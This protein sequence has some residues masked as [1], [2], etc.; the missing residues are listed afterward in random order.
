[1]SRLSSHFI[2][3][4]NTTNTDINSI[5]RL[6]DSNQRVNSYLPY[7]HHDRVPTQTITPI[8][9]EE[10]QHTLQGLGSMLQDNFTMD[11]DNERRNNKLGEKSTMAG[12]DDDFL[13][14]QQLHGQHKSRHHSTSQWLRQRW[15]RLPRWIWLVLILLF[16]M[17][18]VLLM[19]FLIPRMPTVKLTDTETNQ[20]PMWSNDRSS[21]SAEWNVSITLDNSMNWIPTFLQKLNVVVE[22]YDTKAQVGYGLYDDSQWLAPHDYVITM[23]V[24]IAYSGTNAS[25]DTL[26][27]LSTICGLE[28][29]SVGPTSLL[30][31]ELFNITFQIDLS[32][33]GVPWFG[34][35]T[36][37]P[38]HGIQCP[39]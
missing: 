23:P 27:D 35:T 34:H 37:I 29:Q 1:M 2:T 13:Q 5:P 10:E 36:I 15:Y 33:R 7:S 14:Q 12:G 18:F 4:H 19:Y 32:V 3:D 16:I 30:Q 11:M 6:D 8:Y 38:K 20:Y 24:H 39:S 31:S 9:V 28:R 22:D 26:L 17:T 21:M 25:D